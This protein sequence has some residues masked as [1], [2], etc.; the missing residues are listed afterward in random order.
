[1]RDDNNSDAGEGKGL[2]SEFDELRV[3][4]YRLGAIS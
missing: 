4:R 3:A 1:M 2:F